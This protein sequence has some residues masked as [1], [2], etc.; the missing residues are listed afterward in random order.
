MKA[1]NPH[2]INNY[3]D[4]LKSLPA[5]SKLEIISILSDSL[6]STN[7]T[8]DQ[9]LQSLYGSFKSDQSADQIISDLKKGR[10]FNRKIE[11]L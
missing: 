8:K 5:D 9:S 1:G 11:S 6:K 7:Q 4:L 2:I 10:T 3:L